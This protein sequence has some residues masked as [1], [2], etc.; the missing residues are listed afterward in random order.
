M[1]GSLIPN[2]G[3]PWRGPYEGSEHILHLAFISTKGPLIVR[4]QWQFG[5][6]SAIVA[7]KS[8][9]E[10]ASAARARSRLTRWIA[11]VDVRH[12]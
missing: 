4:W 3:V 7:H 8:G 2:G 5:D 1:V 11:M 9:G 12:A 10:D 6:G